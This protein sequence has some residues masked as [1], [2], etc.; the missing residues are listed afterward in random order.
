MAWTDITN[1][2]VAAGAALTTGLL[3]ALRDNQIAFAERDPTAPKIL[4]SVYNYQEF[5]TSGTWTKPANAESGDVVYVH[6]VGAGGSGSRDPSGGSG[7]GGGGGPFKRFEDIDDFGATEAVVVGAGGSTSSTAG[8]SGSSSSFGTSASSSVI[9]NYLI[10]YGGGGG[11]GSGTPGEG[12]DAAH[13]DNTE[14]RAITGIQNDSFAHRGGSGTAGGFSI[15][16]GGH[17][18]FGGGGGAGSASSGSDGVA[19]GLSAYAGHGGNGTDD[20][21]GVVTNYAIDGQFPGGGGGG[22]DQG[23]GS[24]TVGGA[25]ADGIVR[26]WCVKEN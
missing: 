11:S 17:S 22:V 21:S 18:V 10:G 16:T 12:G 5:T 14:D 15:A 13:T 26:V 8:G 2:A 7:G 23:V 24:D 9:T 25:G 4:G 6:V 19:G 1:A 20:T 3:T